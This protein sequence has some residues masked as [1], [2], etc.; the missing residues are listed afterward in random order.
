MTIATINIYCIKNKNKLE[1]F[2]IN[3]YLKKYGSVDLCFLQKVNW[4]FFNCGPNYDYISNVGDNNRGTAVIYRK[5]MKITDVT[6]EANG[7]ITSTTIGKYRYVNIYAPSEQQNYSE[8]KQFFINNLTKHL[9][10]KKTMVPVADFN[11]VISK[12]DS[13]NDA[14]NTYSMLCM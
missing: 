6:G 5:G 9:N 3:K 2:N 1:I 13:Q 12:K 4:D 11:Y 10:I 8:T 14:T 7:R